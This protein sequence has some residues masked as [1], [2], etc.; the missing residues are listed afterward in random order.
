MPGLVLSVVL[1]LTIREPTRGGR[2]SESTVEGN[3][4]AVPEMASGEPALRRTAAIICSTFLQPSLFV[5]CLAG[6]VRN[7]GKRVQLLTRSALVYIK[8][9][10]K[11]FYLNLIF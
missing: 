11:L 5:L 4:A 10:I 8:Y 2:P 9:L 7:A 1:L 6:S 3:S